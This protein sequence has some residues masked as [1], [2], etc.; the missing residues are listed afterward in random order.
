MLEKIGGRKFA[1]ALVIVL[2]VLAVLIIAAVQ[3]KLDTGLAGVLVGAVTWVATQFGLTNAAIT[4]KSMEVGGATT[5]SVS[6]ASD[7]D[8]LAAAGATG[9]VQRASDGAVAVMSGRVEQARS[10]GARAGDAA[11][12]AIS[13]AADA[14]RDRLAGYTRPS[15]PNGGS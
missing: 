1:L 5:G 13:A 6:G 8:V 12:D 10:D 4:R 15:D 11:H 14:A 3:G 7:G 9:T 2:V